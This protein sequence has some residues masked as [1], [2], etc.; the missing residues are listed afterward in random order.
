MGIFFGI[1]IC[2]ISTVGYKRGEYF[3]ILC[4]T[5]RDFRI[6]NLIFS[7]FDAGLTRFDTDEIR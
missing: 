6:V 4:L 1:I 7:L 5:A 2:A 3:F